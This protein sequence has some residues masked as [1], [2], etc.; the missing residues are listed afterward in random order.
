LFP[1]GQH[2][3]LVEITKTKKELER[4]KADLKKL[5]DDILKQKAGH[6][7]AANTAKAQAK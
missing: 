5:S 1:A 4:T 3:K 2:E 6:T 7:L